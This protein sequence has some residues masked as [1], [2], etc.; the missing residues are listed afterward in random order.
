MGG[1]T[2][3]EL[4]HRAPHAVA[5]FINIKGNLAPEDCF[6]TRQILSHPETELHTFLD[7]FINRTLQSPFY[8]SGI[9]AAGLRDRVRP[10]AIKGIFESMVELSDNGDLITKFISVP[11]PRMFMFSEQHATLTY[12]P[13][14]ASNGVELAE[15]PGAGHFPMYSN[16]VAM[17]DVISRFLGRVDLD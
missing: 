16:P 11:F 17:W 8:A 13:V 6:I 10:E 2:A 1:L 12:L 5:S 15:I 14:L 9:Y 3:L 7:D 4:A